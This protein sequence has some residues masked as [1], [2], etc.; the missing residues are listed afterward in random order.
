MLSSTVEVDDS[1]R[2]DNIVKGRLGYVY[3]LP[4]TLTI[5]SQPNWIISILQPLLAICDSQDMGAL[6]E[7]KFKYDF[8]VVMDRVDLEGANET[9]RDS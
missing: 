8:L 5:K 3:S 4:K 6:G 9:I 2:I 7:K 1:N